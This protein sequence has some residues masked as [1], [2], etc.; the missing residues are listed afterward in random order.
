MSRTEMQDFFRR[1][2]A[3][4]QALVAAANIPKQQ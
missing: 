1:D 3:V 2:V 4:N